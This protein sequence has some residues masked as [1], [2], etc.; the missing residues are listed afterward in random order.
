MSG[1]TLP[2]KKTSLPIRVVMEAKGSV[3]ALETMKGEVYRGY[4]MEV[5][6]SLN[7]RLSKVTYTKRVGTSCELDQ[8]F[9]RGSQIKFFVLPDTLRV[10]YEEELQKVLQKH[11][12]NQE[13]N[14][15]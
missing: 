2:L 4:C 10:R 14:G 12:E 13:D 1:V 5:Q 11:K 3:I 15:R 8:V 7:V 9:L 6:E